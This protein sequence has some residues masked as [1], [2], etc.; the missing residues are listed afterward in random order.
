MLNSRVDESERKRSPHETGQHK[1]EEKG[2]KESLLTHHTQWDSAH[3]F[4]S[5]LYSRFTP[6]C[7]TT[8]RKTPKMPRPSCH[9]CPTTTIRDGWCT[10]TRREDVGT[11][12]E[13]G[14]KWKLRSGFSS[15]FHCTLQKNKRRLG[16][17]PNPTLPEEQS[18]ARNRYVLERT[19]GDATELPVR[20]GTKSIPAF[21]I[22]TF[23]T[24]RPVSLLFFFRLSTV[25]QA[26]FHTPFDVVA[27]FF[28]IFFSGKAAAHVT[29]CQFCTKTVRWRL[30]QECQFVMFRSIRG[31]LE[32]AFSLIRD[33]VVLVEFV[34]CTLRRIF[35]CYFSAILRWY[36]YLIW[37]AFSAYF[38]LN[39]KKEYDFDINKI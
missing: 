21:W 3:F 10:H 29:S 19:H 13:R 8:A 16:S 34:Y 7:S 39:H 31:V 1:R 30:V 6:L 20:G 18:T 2:S 24:N 15:R 22:K 27:I 14:E 32:E 12:A 28:F 38:A 5:L 11:R 33:W 36:V 4:S 17:C 25:A 37:F 26:F 35:N 23:F 9:P